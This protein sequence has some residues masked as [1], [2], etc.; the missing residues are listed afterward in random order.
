MGALKLYIVFLT[1]LFISVSFLGYMFFKAHNDHI[2]YESIEL[3]EIPESF[4]GFNIFF[5]SDIHRRKIKESTIEKIDQH[6]DLIIIGGDLIERGVPLERM[7]QNII[8]LK[9]WR[10]PIYFIWGNNDFETN[11]NK[12]KHILMQENVI[13]LEDKIVSIYKDNEKI[14]LI[15]LKYYEDRYA[16]HSVNWNELKDDFTILCTHKPSAFYE[17][18]EAVKKQINVIFAGHTHGGQIRIFGFGFYK[19][20]GTFSYQ[21]STV[22]IS[23][24]YGYTMLPLRLGTRAECHVVSLQQNSTNA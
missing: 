9:K 14:K 4:R 3:Q 16:E 13:M 24:G 10:A 22:I 2:V 17:L 20:G 7:R 8:K 23:E 1:I 19:K 18:N 5:I 12:M 6:I 21:G 11:I 15:G